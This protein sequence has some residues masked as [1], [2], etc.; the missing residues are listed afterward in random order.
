LAT[1]PAPFYRNTL[2]TDRGEKTMGQD[3]NNKKN[4]K[5]KPLKTKKEKRQEKRDKKNKKNIGG[6]PTQ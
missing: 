3:H 1:A 6:I 2:S 4:V 5:R